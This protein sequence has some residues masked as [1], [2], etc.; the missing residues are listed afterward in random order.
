MTWQFRKVTVWNE[1]LKRGV[2]MAYENR[3]VILI[4]GTINVRGTI[5]L[6]CG[7]NNS[8]IFAFLKFISLDK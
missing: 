7:I 1:K 8:C 3:S 2:V 6:V 5:K 4:N